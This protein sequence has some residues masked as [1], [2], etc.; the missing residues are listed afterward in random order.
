MPYLVSRRGRSQET[1]PSP[2]R[3][4]GGGPPTGAAGGDLDGTYPDPGV[5]KVNGVAFDLG[6]P[7]PSQDGFVVTWVDADGNFQ[8]LAPTGGPPSGPA[9]G[10]LDGTYPDPTVS[11]L[12]GNTLTLG[13]LGAGQ[14][15]FVLTWVNTDGQ[16][17]MLAPAGG[18]PSGPAGGDLDGTYPDPGVAQIDGSPVD[19]TDPA[20]GDV[21]QFNGTSWANSPE[22][23]ELQAQVTT[24]AD[25]QV[26]DEA[27]ISA[28]QSQVATLQGQVSDLQGQVSA[29]TSQVSDLQDQVDTIAANQ[30]T[31]EA[32][33]AALQAQAAEFQSRLDC[34]TASFSGICP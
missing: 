15:G 34:F 23:T 4:G 11:A 2:P 32:N 19:I 16:L 10:D 12:Q 31:D 17:E 7:G 20:T 24:I 5:A 1:Y 18:P 6:T 22:L 25:N 28:L 26:T 9:G 3:T 14:D 27:N 29:L 30:V 21:L 33:I 8:V 13:T